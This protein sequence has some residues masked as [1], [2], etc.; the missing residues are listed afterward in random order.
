MRMPLWPHAITRCERAALGDDDRA[1]LCVLKHALEQNDE[2][3][4]D[5]EHRDE[6]ERSAR[7]ARLRALLD[8]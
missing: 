7:L 8:E 1:H 3:Q 4:D 2:D 5:E 6:P